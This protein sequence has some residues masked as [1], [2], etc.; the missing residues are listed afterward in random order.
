MAFYRDVLGLDVV[1]TSERLTALLAGPRQLLLVFKRGASMHLPLTPHDASGHQHVAF[2]IPSAALDAW[3]AWLRERG[4]AVVEKKQWDRGGTSCT[5]RSRRAPARIGDARCVVGVRRRRRVPS[6][7]RDRDEGTHSSSGAD[8][9]LHRPGRARRALVAA[10]GHAARGQADGGRAG[11]RVWRQ[12]GGGRGRLDQ[13][14]LRVTAV[15]PARCSHRQCRPQR[16]HDRQCARA[17]RLCGAVEKPESRHH[18]AWRQRRAPPR[19]GQGDVCEPR[20]DRR[21]YPEPRSCGDPCGSQLRCLHRH[22]RRRL[23]GR[24]STHGVGA[25]AQTS[26]EG[27]SVTRT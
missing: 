23:R 18:R 9:C 17:A 26:W 5:S 11:H 21:P 6:S 19:S 12:S 25:G 4:V 14:R 27:S 13:P 8:P 1:N 3:E 24:R 20:G 16:R 7:E 22:L 2:P 10:P 15:G